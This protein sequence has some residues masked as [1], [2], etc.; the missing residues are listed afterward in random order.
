MMSDVIDMSEWLQNEIEDVAD[1]YSMSE[2]EARTSVLDLL[3]ED[4]YRDELTD[5][6]VEKAI[7]IGKAQG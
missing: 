6:Q 4:E 7:S 3:A 5:E 1:A 2:A